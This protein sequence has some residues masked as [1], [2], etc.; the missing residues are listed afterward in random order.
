MIYC[1]L[2]AE[3]KLGELEVKKD[4]LAQ[5]SGMECRAGREQVENTSR[6][7]WHGED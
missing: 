6:L 5:F 1:K 4:V 3:A 7:V 2:P